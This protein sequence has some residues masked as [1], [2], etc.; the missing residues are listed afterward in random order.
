MKKVLI[1]G[2]GCLA[3]VLAGCSLNTPNTNQNANQAPLTADQNQNV[4]STPAVENNNNNNNNQQQAVTPPTEVSTTWKTYTNSS[5]GYTVQYPSTL[6]VNDKNLSQVTIGTPAVPYV[7]ITTYQLVGNT[8]L[9]SFVQKKLIDEFSGL[10]SAS[11]I[12]WVTIDN[13][14]SKIGVKF[15]SKAGGY[16]GE[17]YWVYIGHNNQVYKI[18]ALAN[19]DGMTQSEF[20]NKIMDSFKFI[21]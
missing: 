8:D 10:L 4:S 3:L 13:D 6:T 20:Q 2:I 15:P 1:L 21:K 17:L 12:K 16:D 5:K 9:Q 7:N 14:F 11:D 19:Y 18:A